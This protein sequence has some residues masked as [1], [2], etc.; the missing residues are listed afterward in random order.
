MN[1]LRVFIDSSHIFHILAFYDAGCGLG[2]MLFGNLFGLVL[3]LERIH[4]YL[5]IKHSLLFL[6]VVFVVLVLLDGFNW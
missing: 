2:V 1:C 5:T 4:K 6:V 3:A